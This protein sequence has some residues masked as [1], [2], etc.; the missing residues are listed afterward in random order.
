MNTL[1]ISAQTRPLIMGILNVTPDSFSDGGR[2]IDADSALRQ[3]EAM[4]Q[5][6]ADIIDVGGESTRPGAE[7]V[8]EQQEL[9]RTIPVIE[10]IKSRFDTWVSLDTSKAEVIKE[11]AKAG[12]DLINDVYA[13][14]QPNA[15]LA[16]AETTLPICL[17]HM[18]GDPKTMQQSPQY[19]DLITEIEA[20]FEN[21]IQQCIAVGISRDRL[22]LDPGFGFG[23]TLSNNYQLLEQLDRFKSF[24]LPL[25]VGLS[26]KSMLG[27]LLKLATDER[28]LASV[29][30]ATLALTK[31]ANIVRVH[32]VAETKQAIQL[33]NAMKYGVSND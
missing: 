5:Q 18:Q 6:G 31:G 32:D 27:N 25:L 20:F 13:L 26:R 8:S 7:K 11:G 29:I 23:K 14:S 15:L 4:I 1:N 12:I 22:V 30:A 3:V 9:E 24:Q 10:A 2:F 28:Q 33:F 16:A 17:M 21:K 19:Q